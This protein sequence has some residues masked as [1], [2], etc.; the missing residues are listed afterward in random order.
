[1]AKDAGLTTTRVQIYAG[2]FRSWPVRVVCR[3][4][5]WAWP[6]RL[7]AERS[8]RGGIWEKLHKMAPAISESILLVIERPT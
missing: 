8:W 2:P 3:A 4:I 5:L 1:V 6:R 7:F